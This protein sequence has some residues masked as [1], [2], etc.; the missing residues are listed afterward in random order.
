MLDI[1]LQFYFIFSVERA[2]FVS[3]LC[4]VGLVAATHFEV[5]RPLVRRRLTTAAGTNTRSCLTTCR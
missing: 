2:F 3:T 1:H 4:G 5:A